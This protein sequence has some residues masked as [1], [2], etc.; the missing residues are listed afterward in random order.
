MLRYPESIFKSKN[1][2]YF[3]GHNMPKNLLRLS[4]SFYTFV[5]YTNIISDTHIWVNMT[6]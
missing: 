6:L 5:A 4:P 3:F 2:I 1:N